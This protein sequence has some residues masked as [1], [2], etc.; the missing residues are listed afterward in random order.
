MKEIL[1]VS[2]CSIN[3]SCCV[4]R[5]IAFGLCDPHRSACTLPAMERDSW[6]GAGLGGQAGYGGKNKATRLPRSSKSGSTRSFRTFTARV[7]LMTGAART[8]LSGSGDGQ[9]GHVW[10]PDRRATMRGAGGNGAGVPRRAW[11]PPTPS[12]SRARRTRCSAQ[13]F[14]YRSGTRPG[15]PAG[16]H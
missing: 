16:E 10:G 14:P 11:G 9:P 4:V 8:E 15:G 3:I 6:E 1:L 2:T 12:S 5:G 7:A 13:C